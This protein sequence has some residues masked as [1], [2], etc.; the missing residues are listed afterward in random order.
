MFI[1]KLIR[2]QVDLPC[3]SNSSRVVAYDLSLVV[4]GAKPPGHSYPAGGDS[5]ECDQEEKAFVRFK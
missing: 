3:Y 4:F 2:K 1:F 5:A